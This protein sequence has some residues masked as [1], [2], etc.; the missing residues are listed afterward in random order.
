MFRK[1]VD[2][3]SYILAIIAAVAIVGMMITMLCDAIGRKIVGTVPIAFELTVGLLV[4]ALMFPKA[5]GQ[6]R[7]VH[8]SIDLFSSRLSK[9]AQSILS[10]I[11]ALLG[12]FVYGVLL[13]AGASRAWYCTKV[14]ESWYSGIMD[15][16]VW[17]FRW[18]IPIG[19]AA[20]ILQ[21]I[22]TAIDEF[23]KARES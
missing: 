11:G 12:V 20:L 15:F 18:V 22:L 14:G 5:F 4:V 7:R 9:K 8:I 10:G 1:V 16:P 3:I 21:F 2:K 6:I 13:W 17:P 19:A 23:R